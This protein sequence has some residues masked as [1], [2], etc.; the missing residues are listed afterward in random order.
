MNPVSMNLDRVPTDKHKIAPKGAF[1]ILLLSDKDGKKDDVK[2]KTDISLLSILSKG[3]DESSKDLKVTK[4]TEK[5]DVKKN[6]DVD[7]IKDKDNSGK[8][9]QRSENTIEAS[10]VN[11][12][13][14]NS[15]K[16]V[17][18]SEDKVQDLHDQKV[19]EEVEK[20]KIEIGNQKAVSVSVQIKDNL[21]SEINSNQIENKSNDALKKI[22]KISDVKVPEK[23]ASP[24]QGKSTDLGFSSQIPVNSSS[25]NSSFF[26]PKVPKTDSENHKDTQTKTDDAK[27][28]IPAKISDQFEKT[29]TEDKVKNEVNLSQVDKANTKINSYQ[30]NIHLTSNRQSNENNLNLK[31]FVMEAKNA[32]SQPV[33]IQTNLSDM[34]NSNNTPNQKLFDTVNVKIQNV[35]KENFSGQNFKVEINDKDTKYSLNDVKV[36]EYLPQSSRGENVQPKNSPDKDGVPISK[37]TDFIAKSLKDQKL[38]VKVDIQLNPPSLGKIEISLTEDGGKT[39]LI[40]NS[41]NDKTQEMLKNAMPVIVDRLSNLNFNIVNVQINGQE[42]Y[43]NS[44]NEDSQRKDERNRKQNQEKEKFSEFFKKEV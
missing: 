32:D 41:S 42:W 8:D 11:L 3:K 33:Q 12:I 26:S 40:I 28:Q 7:N 6:K 2:G 29:K 10:L 22:E 30:Q 24:D 37:I 25:V 31:N 1:E 44:S 16:K 18:N 36:Y 4:E 14:E 15:Q 38:P 13:V 5:S 9:S 27:I 35:V 20:G 19:Q 17:P 43:Q 34:S 39:T 23:V 21:S